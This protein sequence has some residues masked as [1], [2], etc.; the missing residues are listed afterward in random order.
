MFPGEMIILLAIAMTR[1]SGKGLLTHPMDVT[2]EYISYLYNSLVKRGYLTANGQKGYQLTA[3]G[4]EA[5]FEFLRENR[6][7]VKITIGTLQKL[8]IEINQEIDELEKEAIKVK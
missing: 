6:A 8:G 4:S 1:G 7:K 5:L 2:T 3:K